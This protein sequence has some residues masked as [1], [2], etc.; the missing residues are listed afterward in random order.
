M[1]SEVVT[2]RENECVALSSS[3]RWGELSMRRDEA[4]INENENVKLSTPS[5]GEIETVD[6]GVLTER[7]SIDNNHDLYDEITPSVGDTN[8]NTMIN[9][10]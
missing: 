2:G 3:D 1:G 7:S 9:K 10:N 4:A 5:V 8:N 6:M